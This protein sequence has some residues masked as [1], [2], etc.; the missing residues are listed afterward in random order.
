V[1]S[2]PFDRW[3]A[4]QA[5]STDA[6]NRLDE[7]VDL[8]F[9]ERVAE[10]YDAGALARRVPAVLQRVRE[11]V[12]N[13]ASVLEV[14]AGTGAFAL[15]LASTASRITALDHSPAMLRVLRRNLASL[16]LQVKVTPVLG[17]WEDAEVEPHDVVL[18]A[19]ALYRTRDLR[20][21]LD[22]LRRSAKQRLIVVWSIGRQDPPQPAF[23]EHVQPGR[24]RP[25]PDY[26]HL[27][28]GLFA[29]GV[30]ANVEIVGVDDTQHFADDFA[31]VEGLLSWTPI[32][33]EQVKRGAALL[34]EALERNETGWIW[35]RKGRIAIVWWDQSS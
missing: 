13:G 4:L 12:P 25:G 31:A 17:R 11:L 23:R 33:A 9:W 35:R 27:V 29:L 2:D 15:A 14:G 22:K 8:A 7:H 21:V 28:D 19:N 6:S 18:A 3:A 24:Y 30:F 20:C 1:W 5:S 32:T 10:D 16:S 34:P 26:V